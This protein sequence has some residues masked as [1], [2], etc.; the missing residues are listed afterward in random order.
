MDMSAGFVLALT[1]EQEKEKSQ[2]EVCY[3]CHHPVIFSERNHRVRE[4]G[5]HEHLF[6][7]VYGPLWA[8]N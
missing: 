5:K 1:P 8:Q 2:K 6:P 4:D 7:C 3:I